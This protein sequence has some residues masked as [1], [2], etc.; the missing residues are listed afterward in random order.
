MSPNLRLVDAATVVLQ[1]HPAAELFPLMTGADFDALVADI[2]EHGQREAIVVHDGLILD[3]RNRYRACQ[4]LGIE[5]VVVQWDRSG[6]PPEAYAVSMNLHRRHLNESQRAMIAARLSPLSKGVKPGPDQICAR[7]AAKL[8]NVSRNTVIAAK[9]VIAEGEP[10]E[11]AAVVRGEV[12]ASTIAE[13]IRKGQSAGTRRAKREA[14]LSQAGKNPERIQRAQ[15]QAEI[16]ARVNEAL[17]ALTSLPLP[18]DVADIVR[19]NTKRTQT[20]NDRLVRSLQWL[21]DFEDAWRNR[22]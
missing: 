1:P 5:P 4:T 14:P 17:T 13:E 16:W 6:A 19:K 20:V 2:R 18:S 21:K 12:A 9:R 8:L 22:D 11:I 3:G 10:E 15:M 7:D